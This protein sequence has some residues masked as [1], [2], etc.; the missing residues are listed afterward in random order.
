MPVIDP[1]ELFVRLRNGLRQGT[2]R[3][4]K[5]YQGLSKHAEDA[6]VREAM[7][8]RAFVSEKVLATLDQCF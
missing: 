2:E 4:T 6:D 8:A 1:K 5:N 3:G 7:E